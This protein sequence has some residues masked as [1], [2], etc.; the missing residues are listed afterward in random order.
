M[1]DDDLGPFREENHRFAAL[2]NCSDAATA[3]SRFTEGGA[4]LGHGGECDGK[5]DH[6]EFGYAGR[7]L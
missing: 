6:V 4:R 2:W 7:L 5:A 3:A 1:E